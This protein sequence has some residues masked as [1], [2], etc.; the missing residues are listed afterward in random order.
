VS[1]SND[2][3]RKYGIIE[4][5]DDEEESAELHAPP[6]DEFENSIMKE[7]DVIDDSEYEG[8]NN[9]QFDY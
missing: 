4:E 8:F 9:H 2:P 5:K 6:I 1:D 3:M 7:E